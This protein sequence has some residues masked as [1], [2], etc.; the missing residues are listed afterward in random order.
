[1]FENSTGGHKECSKGISIGLKEY[2]D[3]SNIGFLRKQW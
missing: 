2:G 1:M 3:S